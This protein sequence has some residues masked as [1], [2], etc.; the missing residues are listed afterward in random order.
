M[1]II[2]NKRKNKATKTSSVKLKFYVALF[3]VKNQ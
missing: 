1:E 3:L 2:S